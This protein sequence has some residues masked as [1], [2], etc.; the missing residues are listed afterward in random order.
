MG[1]GKSKDSESFELFN[2]SWHVLNY[3][4]IK[5]PLPLIKLFSIQL[6]VPLSELI[7]FRDKSHKEQLL[8]D[9]LHHIDSQHPRQLN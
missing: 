7:T 8:D 5:N 2:F 9:E 3:L 4:V 1:N 6:W